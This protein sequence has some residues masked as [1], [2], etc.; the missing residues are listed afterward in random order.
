[1]YLNYAKVAA[2]FLAVAFASGDKAPRSRYAGR[3]RN[4]GGALRGRRG[5]APRDDA[6]FDAG[7]FEELGSTAALGKAMRATAASPDASLAPIEFNADI[8][9]EEFPRLDCAK[10]T[11]A[12]L[13][14]LK[15]P[16]ACAGMTA[17]CAAKFDLTNVTPKCLAS[18][19]KESWDDF[20]A[21][22]V[23]EITKSDVVTMELTP[24]QLE[25]VLAKLKRVETE[26]KVEDDALDAV[27][28]APVS[29]DFTAF[30]VSSEALLFTVLN[31]NDPQLIALFLSG[32]NLKYVKPSTFEVFGPNTVAALTEKAIRDVSP[33]QF[34]ALNRAAMPGF[35]T[36]QWSALNPSVFVQLSF[37]QAQKVPSSNWNVMSSSQIAKLGQPIAITSKMAAKKAGVELRAFKDNHP[38]KQIDTLA[39]LQAKGTTTELEPKMLAALV[40]Q[41]QPVT[42]L[43]LTGGSSCGW[44]KAFKWIGGILLIVAVV[45]GVAYYVRRK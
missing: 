31:T 6:S 3:G 45:G 19:P 41:C 27:P 25:A 15:D 37:D 14:S 1:M 24:S 18:I 34:G 29:T 35:S 11:V 33:D 36:A 13:A 5:A 9:A 8:S 21:K 43:S 32:E 26:T 28:Y 4:V 16:E 30:V 44:A 20:S 23:E 39:A 10:L 17:S 7:S 2:L 12:L 40:K 22:T 42:E 38:C